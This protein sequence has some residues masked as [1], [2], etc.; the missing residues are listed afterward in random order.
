MVTP[1]AWREAGRFVDW[2]GERIFVREEGRGA[3]VVLVHGFPTA[4]WDWARV[5]PGLAA[6][7]H[8]IAMDLIGFGWSAKP[9][10]FAY[11]VTAYADLVEHVAGAEPYHLVAHDLGDTVAQE[12]L[13]RGAPL[14]TLTLLNGGLFPE[15]HRPR[16]AQELLASPIGPLVA[17]L[18]GPAMFA[19]NMRRICKRPLDDADVDGMWR[20]LDH[21]EGRAVL[22]ALI[23]YMAERRRHR[24]R[25]VGA[26]QQTRVPVRLVAGLDDPISG[27][28]M[29]ARYRE[30]VPHPDVIELGGVGHY[31]QIE[32]PGDVLLAIREQLS[33]GTS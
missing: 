16:L 25:W 32:A 3:R 31:P 6:D 10:G 19:K 27:A 5:W 11:T 2:R 1:E 13:A 15:T 4:S 26:L 24:A 7:H 33:R 29:V 22:P 23:G 20:L 17:R 12:L 28:H 21:A 18:G 14:R 30:V 8:V 9:K